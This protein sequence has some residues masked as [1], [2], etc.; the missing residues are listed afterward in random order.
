MWKFASLF[1]FCSVAYAGEMACHPRPDFESHLASQIKIWNIRLASEEGFDPPP[2]VYVC[3][4]M[5][6]LPVSD[7]VRQRIYL[8]NLA[9]VN[10]EITL[11]HEYLHLAFSHHPRGHNEV[12]IEKMARILVELL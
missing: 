12:Y 10:D 4:L 5:G 2:V 3:Q 7:H 1:L 9:G 8:R 11:A 6:G